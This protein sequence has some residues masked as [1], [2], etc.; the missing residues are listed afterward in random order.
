M[1]YCRAL[2]FPLFLREGLESGDFLNSK[3]AST[4]QA[5]PAFASRRTK[6]LCRDRFVRIA[7]CAGDRAQQKTCER[8]LAQAAE[9][10]AVT[11]ATQCCTGGQTSSRSDRQGST[12][13]RPPQGSARG[14]YPAERCER[15]LQNS[16]S[17]T[18]QTAPL[19]FSTRVKHLCSDRLCLTAFYRADG[20]QQWVNLRR[21]NTNN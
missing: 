11:D 17:S 5:E 2:P 7:F 15:R 18:V 12:F 9:R 4:A 16:T 14:T 13:R 21:L 10:T 1:P 20:T 19:T 3:E 8:T 6:Y